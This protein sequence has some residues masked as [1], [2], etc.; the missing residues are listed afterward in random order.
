MWAPSAGHSPFLTYPITDLQKIWL[1]NGKC[2]QCNRA[3]ESMSSLK[4]TLFNRF[5]TLAVAVRRETE[6]V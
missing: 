6:A 5:N 3:G 1:P 2:H 4:A